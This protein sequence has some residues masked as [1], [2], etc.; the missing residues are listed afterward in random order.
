MIR[1]SMILLSLSGFAIADD[2][3][4]WTGAAS[5]DWM[6]PGNWD[7]G[8]VPSNDALGG[9]ADVLIGSAT[10][11]TWPVLDSGDMPPQ[12][13]DL[14]IA[15][16]D[17][18]SGELIV[19][20]GVNLQLNDDI[21]IGYEPGSVSAKFT[22]EGAGTTVATIKSLELGAAGDV[23]VDV[24]GGKLEIGV[25]DKPKWN[26]VVAE[27]AESNVTVT[28]RNG[29]LIEHHGD[30]A[31]DERGGLKIGEG[32]ALIDI[33]S[34][35]GSGGGTLKLKNDVTE[36][37][38]TLAREGVIVADG[39]NRDV[40][41][42]FNDGY[43]YVTASVLSTRLNPIPADGST[44]PGGP[45]QL[46]WTLPASS[47]P[48]GI[49][50]CDVYFGTNPNVEVNPKVVAGQAVESVSVTLALDTQ[51]YWALDVYDSAVSTVYPIYLSPVFTLNTLNMAP[52]VNAGEDIETWLADGPRVV[53]LDGIVSDEDTRPEPTTLLWMVTDEPNPL[54]P[55]RI[56][57]PL[58]PNPTVTISEPG[59]YTLQL[60]ASDG[61]YTTTDTMQIV[62]YQDACEHAKNQEGFEL[63]P[64]DINEDC[65]VNE[66]DL[67]ILE[68]HWLEWNYSF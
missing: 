43:T 60:E 63:I 62:L 55:A 9:D 29:G 1:M 30:V 31:E 57:D 44:V 58:V 51:Y 14:W 17:G 34:D 52:V 36:L 23:V 16:G 15:N 56:S 59:A 54:Y 67:A 47:D 61:Q 20:G 22:I 50:T 19:K 53:Q 7:V 42:L 64:G 40:Q 28:I 39:G 46:Q 3:Y 35:G 8:I 32:K 68:E 10:P 66:L 6:T 13:D 4:T 2:I 48:S 5:D 33:G 49:V 45:I 27:G 21:K 38:R 41:I 18:L 25:V 11:L 24:N 65:I 12:I 37:V 26:M